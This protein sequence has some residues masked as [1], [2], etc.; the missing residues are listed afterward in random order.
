[1]G[2]TTD[3]PTPKRFTDVELQNVCFMEPQHVSTGGQFMATKYGDSKLSI[4]TP[5][6]ETLGCHNWQFGGSSAKHVFMFRCSPNFTSWCQ[7]LDEH[8]LGL[9][10][11]NARVWFGKEYEHSVI[12]TWYQPTIKVGDDGSAI[13]RLTV[14]FRGDDCLVSFFDSEKN[15]VDIAEVPN[16]GIAS[17]IIELEGLWFYNRKFG[18]RWKLS[19]VKLH[20]NAKKYAFLSDE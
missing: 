4:Q 1:M 13:M 18:C 9:A 19:Q 8:V 7:S 3:V 16:D 2:T 14:P 5:R 17:A 6:M 10:S 11:K 12:Q 20:S 15:M